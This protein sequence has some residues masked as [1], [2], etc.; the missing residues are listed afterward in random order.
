MAILHALKRAQAVNGGGVLV[1]DV[2]D[3]HAI[4]NRSGE[5]DLK[6]MELDKRRR[7]MKAAIRGANS[8][9]EIVAILE[10]LNEH[11]S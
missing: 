1:E 2:D 7:A 11:T 10:T 8:E 5:M 4:L 3:R 6:L 9:A